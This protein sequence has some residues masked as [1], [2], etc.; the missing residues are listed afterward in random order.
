[1]APDPP[2]R[3]PRR[4]AA[5]GV[6]DSCFFRSGPQAGQRK[7]LFQIT[8]RCDLHCAHCFVSATS[9]GKDMELERLS[10]DVM[11]RVRDARVANVTLTGGEPFVH[12]D[13]LRLVTRFVEN[14]IDVTVCTNGA[15]ASDSILQGMKEL[16]R[17]KLNVS[18]D[19]LS[20]S[21]HGRFRGDS[22]S[23]DATFH[24]VHRF[25]DA[26]LLKGILS[27][28]N[29][30]AAPQEYQDLYDMA[31]ALQVEYL[32]MNPLSAFGRGVKSRS[33]LRASDDVMRQIAEDLTRP[34]P[35]VEGPEVVLIRF[36]NDSKPLTGC[37]AGDIFYVF[38]NGSAAVCPYLVFA[39]NTPNSQHRPEEFIVGNLFDDWDFVDRL[40]N[41]KLADRFT[42]GNNPT[43]SSCSMSSDCGKGCPAAVVAR[44]ARIGDLDSEVCPVEPSRGESSCS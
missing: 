15:S 18:L 31:S 10:A 12:P 7:A 13:L 14:D 36:P 16:G 40:D 21:S 27:T 17:V 20:S 33:R 42:L 41:Y 28:P 8:E 34:L 38:V 6:A 22:S 24:N 1:M 3:A 19:G 29:A 5:A 23:F 25:A 43:C 39:A 44:G 32:L 35:D 30:L 37:I 11:T 2:S 4:L 26:G 9:Q